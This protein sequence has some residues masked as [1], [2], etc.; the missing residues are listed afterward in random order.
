[1]FPKV[2]YIGNKN[3]IVDWIVDIIPE[4]VVTILDVFAGGGSV[5]YKLKEQGFRIVSNDVLYSSF[6]V[7]KALVENN[8]VRLAPAKLKK[9]ANYEMDETIRDNIDFLS[10]TLYFPSEV[11]ELAGLIS[12]AN[13]ELEGYEYYMFLALVRRAMIRK[14]P[15]SR[16]NLN[17]DNIV[18]LRDEDY[19]Y[20]KYGRKRAYHNV[21]FIE[22]MNAS[23]SEY[24]NAV[25]QGER[26]AQTQQM[27]VLELLKGNAGADLVYLDPPYPGTMNNY[28]GFYGAFDKM[29]GKNIQHMDLTKKDSFIP[30]MELILDQVKNKDYKY[31]LISLN[32]SIK[33]NFE[34][35][36]ES[37][38]KYGDI[39]IFEKKHNY[40]VSGTSTKQKNV[41]LLALISF[42]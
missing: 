4:D 35:F 39:K 21:P 42:K 29:F 18:K 9:A 16:M 19:S 10:K 25:F 28:D 5:S 17:W 7:N 38:Q 15:Y 41:E 31:A 8:S 13:E 37:I 20:A 14:L 24:N 6:V 12:Y 36:V 34:E 30:R 11:D 3:K 27:D 1:M 32:K 26:D 2:N 33:P 40:Q 23:L 22:H